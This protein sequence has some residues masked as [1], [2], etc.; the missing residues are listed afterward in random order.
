MS[1]PLDG[2]E[3]AVQ[4]AVR[5]RTEQDEF[6][7]K[8]IPESEA[9]LIVAVQ[10]FAKDTKVYWD[11]YCRILS[12]NGYA[13]L[14]NTSYE[15]FDLSSTATLHIIREGDDIRFWAKQKG[16]KFNSQITVF[17]ITIVDG[18]VTTEFDPEINVPTLCYWKDSI[19]DESF[20]AVYLDRLIRHIAGAKHD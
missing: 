19:N 12:E 10:K 9:A 13:Y 17:D 20:Q 5:E 4:D 18:K 6:L 8:A 1:W 15:H 3:K 11:R 16:C 7:R 14:A 2:F